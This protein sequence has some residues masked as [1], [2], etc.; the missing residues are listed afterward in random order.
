MQACG[1][2]KSLIQEVDRLRDYL[3][4]LLKSLRAARDGEGWDAVTLM[5]AL[6]SAQRTEELGTAL[7][8]LIASARTKLEHAASV[9]VL[10]LEADVRD[11]CGQRGWSVDGHWPRL[12][13]ER[14]IEFE[15]DEGK[16]TI[17]IGGSKLKSFGRQA[18]E[19]ALN[20]AVQELIPRGFDLQK[21][22]GQLAYAYDQASGGKGGEVPLLRVYR[23][24]VLLSQPLVL[25][26]DARAASF[27]ELSAAQFRARLS[28]AL[29]AG[30]RSEPDGRE[31]RLLPPIDPKD[32]MFI[33]QPAERRLG[34]VGR[35][36]F[37]QTR[38]P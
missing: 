12:Y 24:L 25:W 6:E 18:V 17:S 34:F 35:I 3:A 36:E 33:Y 22:M 16:R 38:E 19:S 29:E 11:L 31:L 14:S 4:K 20:R 15:V 28:A 10:E 1:E 37:R 30:A 21:F 8:S 2:V 13:I 26:R 23:E 27:A 5:R 32:A 9:S 7:S